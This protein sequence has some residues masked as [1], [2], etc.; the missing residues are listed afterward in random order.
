MKL[1]NNIRLW[2]FMVM[3]L[4][5][6]IPC[7]F[8]EEDPRFRRINDALNKFTRLYPQQKVYLHLD[9]HTYLGGDVLWIKAYLINGMD[10]LPDTIST[11]LYVE[12]IS[13]SHTR[14]EIKRL[15]MFHGFGVGDF[16]L[17]DT[18]PEGLYQIRAYTAWMQNFNTAFY[19]EKNFQVLNPG[20]TKL[21]T[22]K[23]AKF[24]EQQLQKMDKKSADL[25]LQFMPE[26]GN[27]VSGLES[28]IA[29]K[30]VN[31][32][33]K[34]VAVNGTVY[35][36]KG[37]KVTAFSS[38]YKGMGRFTFTPQ[39]GQKYYVLTDFNGEDAKWTLPEAIETG[40]V[41]RVEHAPDYIRV[42]I[43]SNK[44][45]TNDP[46]ANE[47]IVT[48]QVGG[49][50]Y[51]SR[52]ARLVENKAQL[53]I[54]RLIL[55]GGILQ[56]TIFSGRGIPLAER[57]AFS[58]ATGRMNIRISASDSIGDDG[59]KI[60][61]TVY[62]HTMRNEPLPANLSVSVTREFDGFPDYNNDNILSNILLNSDL[63]GYIEDP[64][65]YFS[66]PRFETSI[67]LDNLLLTQGW[68]RFDWNSIIAGEYPKILYH[69]EKGI[70]IAGKI[71]R[72]FF[73]IPIQNAKVRL[74]IMTEFNDVFTEFTTRKGTFIFE[75]LVYYDTVSV[76]I[77]AWKPNGRKNVQILLPD[78]KQDEVVGHEGEY[79]ITTRSDMGKKE[80][81]I[82]RY[83]EGR[84]LMAKQK[85][86]HDKK[87]ENSLVGI[88][89][90]PDFVLYNE[91]F[92][93]RTGNILD[94]LNGRVP[95]VMV[96]G[97][98]VIIRGINTIYGSTEPLYLLDG[99]PV[100]DVGAI[101]AIPLEDIERVEVL[102]GPKTA[103]YGS[104]GANGV[105]AVFTKRGN[106]MIRGRIEFDM[107][108]YSTPRIFYQPRYLPEKE[109]PVNYTLLW[110]SVVL[111]DTSGKATL[112][113][114][115]PD[116]PGSYKFD[117]QGLSYN[118]HV[119]YTESMIDNL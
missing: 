21:I 31:Q 65:D 46:T 97:D 92:P 17:S 15:Q 116:I 108:G 5:S 18:L 51:F 43:F 52:I 19:F 26:G 28:V 63:T 104:R 45:L 103:F 55:P 40:I 71:T 110:Q 76:K 38:T 113:F 36:I 6:L 85:A 94:V 47:L 77:E 2:F 106:F 61:L 53:D 111:T 30:A 59:K 37:N 35:D 68:R 57:L 100:I 96:S 54:P 72:D 25:D 9:K 10:H 29:F 32:F 12:I 84:A 114:D 33:G 70:T 48:G 75:N 7:S 86:A 90:E 23:E 95:G 99:I 16:T 8:A 117:I 60:K 93:T 44:P 66:I 42:S 50:M 14:V 91:D 88:Y 22:P 112:V 89:G 49:R 69:E 62:S 41:M 27:L 4:T 87:Y 107:L 118:G 20:Y 56:I 24:N 11:N 109:P 58:N 81:R 67:E 13:P 115:K 101:T 79:V 102:K 74:S 119:G 64:L 78:A 73:G 39:K 105:I 98:N 82:L 1:E 80:Y 34:G 3:L 83:E